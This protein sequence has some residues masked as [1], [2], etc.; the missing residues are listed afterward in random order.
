MKYTL[1]WLLYS[2]AFVPLLV[3]LDTLFPF[4]FTKTLLIRFAVTLFWILFAVFFFTKRKE[5]NELLEINWRFIKNPLYIFVSLFILVMLFSTIFAVNPYKAF[6]GDIERG[7]GFLG[8]LHF[9]GF[10]IASLLV[11]KKSD[12]ATFFRFNLITGAALLVDSIG[13]LAS[14]EFIRA[15]SFI[16]NPTFLAG[17]FLF[18][19]LSA[20]LAFSMSKERTGWRIFSFLMIFGGTAGVFLTGTR[21]AIVGLAF[22]ILLAAVYFAVKGKDIPLN[23]GVA[24]TDMQK[25]GIAFIVIAVLGIGGFAITRDNPFWKKIPGVSR[26]TDL[27][28]NDSTLQTRLISAG[29]SLNAVNPAE[30]GAHRLLIGY[31]WDNFN[32]AY[33][34]HFNP[35]YMRYEPL[36]FDRAHNKIFDVLVMTGALGLFAYLGA[37]FLLFYLAFKKIPEKN[38]AAA[39]IFFGG[40]F[41]VQNLFVFDQI[42]TYIPFFAFL[43]FAVF[44]SSETGEF[45]LG[46]RLLKLKKIFEKIV[47]YKLPA[48]GALFGFGLIAYTLVPYSQSIEFIKVLQSGDANVALQ[49]LEAYTEPYNYGQSTIRNRLLTL[50]VPLVGNPNTAEFVNTS[51]ALQEEFVSK[52]PYDPRDLNLMGTAYRVK[53]NVGEPGAYE[54]AEDYFLRSLELSPTRQ[55]NL[56]NLGTLYA[57]QGNFEK[58]QEYAGILLSQAPSVPRTEILYATLIAREGANRCSESVDVLNRAVDDPMVYFGGEGEENVIRNVYNLCIDHLFQVRDEENFLAALTGARDFELKVDEVNEAEFESGIIDS[59]PP[60][61]AGEL[62][63]T[64]QRFS[65]GG[66]DALVN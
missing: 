58:M 39:L 53:G 17:Y 12:W 35:E 26:F 25:A 63:N 24:K 30:N 45:S 11:F 65:L 49:N 47:P 29:V 6:F 4:I 2:L 15:Q 10:F 31:G 41:F 13:E 62:E 40:A 36:W 5:A 52:E 43:A 28:L 59:V 16:G 55:D 1:K 37:W 9:F 18:V 57:D 61:R 7:E 64:L 50:A 32:I 27:S 54:K 44:S 38:I 3:N 48:V 46:K 22:G 14:G 33:N 42:S 23:L 21:G 20:L 51:L 56:Y 34:K 19:I 60:S 66:F 8:M